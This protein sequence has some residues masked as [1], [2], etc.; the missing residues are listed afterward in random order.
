MKFY[1]V[2]PLSLDILTSSLTPFAIVDITKHNSTM[3]RI[4][5]GSSGKRR[6][7]CGFF[8]AES[9]GKIKV[10]DG[11]ESPIIE[12]EKAQLT[13]PTSKRNSIYDLSTPFND[14]ADPE[15]EIK[16]KAEHDSPKFEEEKAKSNLSH[17][18][19]RLLPETKTSKVKEAPTKSR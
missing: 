8:K 17:K 6:R 14:V 12:E 4:R 11:K 19:I 10:H 18:R 3:P 9:E 15:R 2:G 5:Q 13:K 7:I 16:E 1:L